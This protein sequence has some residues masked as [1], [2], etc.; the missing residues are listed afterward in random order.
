MLERFKALVVEE[1]GQG[2]VEYGLIIGLISVV[3]I[4]VLATMGGE[5]KTMF[6]T[7][8]DELVNINS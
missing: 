7:V 8:K 4:T 1:E 2:M 6:T 3:V 5:L